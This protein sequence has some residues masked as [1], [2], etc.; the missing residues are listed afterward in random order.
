MVAM[1]YDCCQYFAGPHHTLKDFED[2]MTTLVART[3]SQY[4]Y[5][6]TLVAM[7]DDRVVG[8][9]VSYDG[10]RLHELRKAFIETAASCFEQDFSQMDDETQ[11]GELYLDSLAVVSDCRHKGIATALLNAT[12]EKASAMGIPQVGLLVDQGNPLAEKLYTAAGFSY[13][14]DSAWGGHPMRHLVRPV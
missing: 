4:S 3:D 9:A 6:N 14:G 8:I 13:A 7:E 10:T 12:A 2:A 11:A 5:L 1:N